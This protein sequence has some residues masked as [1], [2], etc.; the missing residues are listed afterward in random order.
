MKVSARKRVAPVDSSGFE[1]PDR[2]VWR[3]PTRMDTVTSSAVGPEPCYPPHEG[4]Y[5]ADVSLG[6]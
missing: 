5:A 1:Q 3:V 2:D 4:L 6:G